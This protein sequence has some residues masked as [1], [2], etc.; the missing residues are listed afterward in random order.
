VTPFIGIA[1]VNA[2]T[3]LK[4]FLN[5]SVRVAFKNR[6]YAALTI[7]SFSTGLAC[8]GLI[9]IWLGQQIEFDRMHKKAN[10][11]FQVNTTVTDQSSS[12]NQA[13]TPAPLAPRL[14]SEVPD[15]EGVLRMDVS[16]AVVRSGD[17]KFNED[18]IIATDPS[19]FNFFDFKLIKGNPH[20][21]LSEP[22]SV[23]ISE[24]I[25]KKYFGK[26]DPINQSLRIFQYDP[27]GRGAEFKIT[28]VIEDCPENSHFLYTMLISFSTIEVAEPEVLMQHGW[29]NHEYYTYVMLQKS[30]ST[31]SVQNKIHTLLKN[32]VVEEEYKRYQYFLTPL[33]QIHFQSDVRSQIR[34]GVS[35]AYMLSFAAIAL[36]VL[37]FACINYVNLSTAY[38]MDR[39]K[40]VGIRKVL[41]SSRRQLVVQ[42]V[43]QSWLVA[44]FAIVVSLGWMEIAKPLFEAVLDTR[45]TDLYSVETLLL[46][47]AVGSAAGV[48]SGI[49][50][51]IVISSLRPINT[52][53]GQLTKGSSGMLVRKTLVVIQYAVTVLLII[54]I[55]TVNRQ[56]RF[57]REKD[58]GFL[59]DNL[60][61]MSMNGSPEA[62][63][64]YNTFY[65][66]LK[67]MQFVTGIARSNTMIGGGLDKEIAVAEHANGNRINI[68]I[69]TVGID[70]DYLSTY[71][72]KL[73]AGRNFIPG[74]SSDSV[75]I[76]LNEMAAKEL[77]YLDVHEIIGKR[78]SVGNRSGSVIGVIKN[79]HQASLHQRIEPVALYL[80]NNYYSRI[81]IRVSEVHE[82]NMEQ[83]ET[84]WKKSFP[85][86]VFDFRF[87]DVALNNLYKNEER[88][89]KL[90]LLFSILSI[91]IASLG[92]FA[93][94]SYTVDRRTKE[95]GVRKVL[96]AS[97]LQ[98]SAL[99][100]REFLILVSVSCFVAM[101]LGWYLM[102]N[103]L[104]NFV[105]HINMGVEL[106]IGSALFIVLLALMTLS[107]K[108]LS[109]AMSNPVSSLRTE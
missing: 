9:T 106:I 23:V 108:T 86:T 16:D 76:I 13:V 32:N 78:F 47:I 59:P 65:N 37:L 72:M 56:M 73:M 36:V 103:W 21:V 92:L 10:R 38:A 26:S 4:I 11:I 5:T 102:T 84:L 28:G 68:D 70:H 30:G 95:I 44:M 17:V 60:V 43:M 39:Y 54:A 40:E 88:F 104:N 7:F 33:T 61:V 71:G 109:A 15:L 81:S 94:I 55:V 49:Y 69:N 52:L 97:T 90:F 93:L 35:K 79:F 20:T 89:A 51:A 75:G 58:I 8:F 96:G 83:I 87:A 45:L 50:P 98:V 14:R 64:G 53:K 63:P 31:E 19:F 67:S 41:G 6:V 42:Y 3:M 66:A 24:G 107:L 2:P 1:I 27:D 77:G 48:L 62:I 25:A 46:L 101:P 105:Y 80:L 22:Y 29:Q 18:G 91:I 99:L 85:S 74:Q 100:T 34:P 82:N 12:W 57:I